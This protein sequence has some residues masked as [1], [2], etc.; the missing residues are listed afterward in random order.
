[1]ARFK[2]EKQRKAAMA[3]MNSLRSNK[4]GFK[5]V[6]R[7]KFRTELQNGKGEG[8]LKIVRVDTRRGN[9]PVEVWAEIRDFPTNETQDIR[10][11]KN[12][13]EAEKYIK[14]IKDINHPVW[15]RG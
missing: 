1:M 9:E 14:E 10:S 8:A 6:E 3:R 2:S 11:F 15:R 12:K 13:E 5:V 7:S 4:T